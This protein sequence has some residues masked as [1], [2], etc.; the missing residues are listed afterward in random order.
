MLIG[1]MFSFTPSSGAPYLL[2]SFAIVVLGGMGNI[3]GTMF[4]GVLI[5]VRQSIDALALGDGYRDLV[6]L[7]VFLAVLALRPNGILNGAAR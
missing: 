2:T 3:L 7:V 4:G 6:G 5:G 1:I